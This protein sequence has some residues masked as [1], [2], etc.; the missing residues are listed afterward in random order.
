[1]RGPLLALVL[2][3]GAILLRFEG[4]ALEYLPLDSWMYAAMADDPRVYTATPWG[5][6]LLGPLLVSVAPNVRD[7]FAALMVFSLCGAG[8]AMF[9]FLRALGHGERA[10]LAGVLAFA[11]TD[12]FATAV[13]N[14]YLCEPLTVFLACA[15]LAALAARAPLGLLALVA[16][17]GA[18]S[19]EIFL[20]L[21]PLVFLVRRPDRGVPRALAEAA[22][23]ATPPLLLTALLRV[24]WTPQFPAVWGLPGRRVLPVLWERLGPGLLDP[25]LLLLGLT[26][27]ALIGVFTPRGR[28][29]RATW[30]PMALV[31]FLL[32]FAAWL[33][34]PRPGRL[35]FFGETLH[36]LWIYAVPLMIPL[37]LALWPRDATG[38][39]PGAAPAA[40]RAWAGRANVPGWIGAA[41]VASLP[42]WALD[43][44]RRGPLP[45]RFNGPVVR[46]LFGESLHVA[47]AM[48]RGDKLRYDLEAELPGRATRRAAQR[49]FLRSGWGAFPYLEPGAVQLEQPSGEISVPA[50]SSRPLYLQLTLS[51]PAPTLVRLER[52]G[53]ELG[54]VEVAE[55]QAVGVWLEGL[56]RGDNTV[57]VVAA[58][59]LRLHVYELQPR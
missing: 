52:A 41:L 49:F 44:Y 17:L 4:T 47:R 37:A 10:A 56:V 42:L 7:G 51:A 30:A 23:V 21:L 12:P 29:L 43:D 13:R 33:Y 18:L 32:P 22:L 25:E 5:Y 31:Y 45:E 35:P 38:R 14:P 46:A 9:L 48:G 15:F 53:V 16:T 26:P 19:K 2:V 39:P 36:R 59:G 6:R 54:R 27:L 11:V 40:G 28:E 58:P 50:G 57:R 24:A 34:D 55:R 20:G 8:A 1:M 3:A